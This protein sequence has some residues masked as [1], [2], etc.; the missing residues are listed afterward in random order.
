LA[1]AVFRGV[2]DQFAHVV[3]AGASAE[4]AA[5]PPVSDR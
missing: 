1:P 5:S 4:V 2:K 3:C